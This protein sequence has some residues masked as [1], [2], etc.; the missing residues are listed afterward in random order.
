MR[1]FFCSC[2][3]KKPTIRL[4]NMENAIDTSTTHTA[5]DVAKVFLELAQKK[6]RDAA[7]D[8]TNMKLNKLV[9]FAQ[10]M[11]VRTLGRTIP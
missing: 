7:P 8:M 5:I 10:V 2:E 3:E 1:L 6:D 11:S 4:E 9:Y